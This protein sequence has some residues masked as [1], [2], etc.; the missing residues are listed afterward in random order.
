MTLLDTFRR[1]DDVLLEAVKGISDL[2]NRRGL[3]NLDF[4]DIRTVMQA[5]GLALMMPHVWRSPSPAS[6]ASV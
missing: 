2:I 1:A 6:S 5:K 3:I 4:A